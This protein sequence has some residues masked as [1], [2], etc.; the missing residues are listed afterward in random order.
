MHSN[1]P[2][3]I[4]QQWLASEAGPA[5]EVLVIKNSWCDA[6]IACQGAQVLHYQPKQKLPI[7]WLSDTNQFQRGK[8]I[9]GGIPLCFPSTSTGFAITWLC[10]PNGMAVAASQ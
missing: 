3:G 9:R 6:V 7:L 5:I 10:P 2:S 4:N 1:L 8:A